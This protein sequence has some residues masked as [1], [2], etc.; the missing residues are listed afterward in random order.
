MTDDSWV[1]YWRNGQ[2]RTLAVRSG[3]SSGWGSYPGEVLDSKNNSTGSGA[4]SLGLELANSKAFAQCQVDKV[5]K[6]VCFRD[7]NDKAADRT[8]RNAV[9][10]A[11]VAGGYKMKQVFGDIAAA[12]KGN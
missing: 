7:P 12:C 11:F 10:D 1:N 4:K 3:S 8:T 5:F 6:S 2:N 9:V